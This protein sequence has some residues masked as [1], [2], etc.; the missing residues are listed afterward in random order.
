VHGA[1]NRRMNLGTYGSN[2]RN[3]VAGKRELKRRGFTVEGSK[4]IIPIFLRPSSVEMFEGFK[5]STAK[6]R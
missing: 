6:T 2:D 5:A 4:Y 3:D 1:A